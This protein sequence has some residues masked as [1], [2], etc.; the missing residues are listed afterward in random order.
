MISLIKIIVVNII[1]IECFVEKEQGSYDIN[2]GLASSDHRS[3]NLSTPLS[4]D[5][6]PCI[7]KISLTISLLPLKTI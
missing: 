4:D 3:S 1:I 5:S 6:T 7:M 2:V